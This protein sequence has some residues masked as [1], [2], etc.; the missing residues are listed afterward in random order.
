[1]SILGALT[2]NVA[3]SLTGGATSTGAASGT[4]TYYRGLP[5][6]LRNNKRATTISKANRAIQA[7][8][9]HKFM[10]YAC[11]TPGSGARGANFQSWQSGFAFQINKVDRAKASPKMQTLNQYNRKRSVHT[12]IEYPD[13]NLTLHD[14]VDDRV[15]RV[16][17]DYHKW[18]F[19]DGRP[20]NSTAWKSGVIQGREDFPV[21]NGWGFSPQGGT[22]GNNSFFDT[23][24]VYTFY[25]KK[26]TQV[27]FYNPK[28]EG[29]TFDAMDASATSELTT[30]DMTI[31]HEGFAYT[32]VAAP[33]GNKEIEL[34]GL[35]LGDYFEPA[36]AFGG[37]NSFLLDL[38]DQLENTVDSLLGGVSNIPFVGGV[39]AGLGSNAIRAS[40]VT[41]FLPRAARAIS[42]TSLSRWGSFR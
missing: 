7:T 3:S 33:V 29:I 19:G 6:M 41:G 2:G 13:L 30:I 9:R 8:P 24:D 10:F 37:V 4:R 5:I 39:L 27:T 35:N 12:G 14:T 28:I 11:F 23:L 22:N 31:K 21:T 36:D 16:W 15:L 18:Y 20:K 1:M 42:G 38:N 32:Q 17:R 40:G 26:Y 34:F 25:G